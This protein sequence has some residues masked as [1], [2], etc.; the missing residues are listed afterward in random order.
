MLETVLIGFGKVADTLRHDARM[1]RYFPDASHAQVLARHDVFDWTAVV[2]VSGE[3]RERAEREW[4]IS[5]T[6]PVIGA[7]EAR[8]RFEAAVIASPPQGRLEIIEA[9]PS[10]RA[11]LVEKPLGRTVEEARAFRDACQKRD[12]AVQVN[13]WRRAVPAFRKYAG[14]D[15]GETI[16]EVQAVSGIYG[17]GLLNNGSHLVDFLRMLCGEIMAIEG[18]GPFIAADASSVPGDR[19][20]ACLLRLE[21]GASASLAPVDFKH[22]REVGL[23]IWGA[24]GRL[25]ITQESLAMTLFPL[26]ENRGL[27]N[28]REIDSTDG[29]TMKVDTNGCLQAMYDT[30]ADGMNDSRALLCPAVEAF[31]SEK[32]VHDIMQWTGKQA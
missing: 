9:L 8:E 20:T 26:A 32:I 31:R 5:R 25:S 13:Y 18:C 24:S 27:E 12:I 4:K 2:D 1:A 21:N 23:D 16:G 6:A 10:L 28:E 29:K 14:G 3:A 15:L 19:E 7:L 30:L 22:W 11:V 17:N